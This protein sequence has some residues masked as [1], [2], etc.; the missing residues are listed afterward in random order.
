MI[1]TASE[2]HTASYSMVGKVRFARAKVARAYTDHLPPCSNW[3]YTFDLPYDFRACKGTSPLLQ[4][5]ERMEM[6]IV[7]VR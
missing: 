4:F 2:T 3:S 1:Q 7:M 6:L 5:L